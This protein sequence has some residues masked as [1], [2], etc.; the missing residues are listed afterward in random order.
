MK[1]KEKIITGIHLMPLISSPNQGELN[2]YNLCID[3]LEKIL[4][5][6]AIEFAE[7]IDDIRIEQKILYDTSSIKELLKIYKQDL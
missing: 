4:D 2:N 3:R 5:N 7:W 6:H 1:L